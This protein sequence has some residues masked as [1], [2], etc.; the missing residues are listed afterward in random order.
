MLLSPGTEVF[1]QQRIA[2]RPKQLPVQGQPLSRQRP[3]LPAY[4]PH[5]LE[6]APAVPGE[7]LERVLIQ[8]RGQR[9]PGH[10]HTDD[11][12]A[13]HER[14]PDHRE[15]VVV[16]DHDRRWHVRL[17]QAAS[18]AGGKDAEIMVAG[19]EELE[20]VGRMHRPAGQFDRDQLG[21]L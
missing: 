14:S 10:R 1:L 18:D 21:N 19:R 20:E 12:A 17:G 8:E 11:L 2:E 4:G 7:P 13:E 5:Y 6:G 3:L 15:A 9:I 16:F